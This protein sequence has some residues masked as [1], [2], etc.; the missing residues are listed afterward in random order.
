MTLL[1]KSNLNSIMHHT[2]RSEFEKV[3]KQ[4]ASS[5]CNLRKNGWNKEAREVEKKLNR[6]FKRERQLQQSWL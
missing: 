4:L 5:S 1:F 2:I 3:V 6:V